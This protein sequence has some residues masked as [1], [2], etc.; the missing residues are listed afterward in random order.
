[1][2]DYDTKLQQFAAILQTQQ[3]IQCKLS[4]VG[5]QANLDN[6][7]TRIVPGKKYDKVNVGGSGR[8]MVDR[9]TGEIYGIK[10]YGQIHK[11]RTY[12]TLDGIARLWWG[13][14]SPRT[15][16]ARYPAPAGWETM[17]ATCATETEAEKAAW[18][19]RRTARDRQLHGEPQAVITEIQ[20]PYGPETRCTMMLPKFGEGMHENC[21]QVAERELRNTTSHDC[22]KWNESG[23]TFPVSLTIAKDSAYPSLVINGH[24]L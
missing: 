23:K 8:F 20:T 14:Y 24:A 11:G 3:Q 19:A 1:M 18:E 10:G 15:I 16:D 22:K 12:G 17:V 5:C 2:N 7:R 21:I 13:G 6:C 9:A 4:G